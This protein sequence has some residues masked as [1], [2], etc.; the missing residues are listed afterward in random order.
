VIKK[1]RHKDNIRGP[2][3]EKESANKEG[4]DEFTGKAYGKPSVSLY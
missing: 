2:V 1:G 4:L 3:K